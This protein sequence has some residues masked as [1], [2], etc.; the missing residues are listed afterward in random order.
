MA[1]EVEEKKPDRP[2]AKAANSIYPVLNKY[3]EKT[4]SVKELTTTKL[5]MHKENTVSKEGNTH[6]TV[7]HT[8]KSESEKMTHTET[9]LEATPDGHI[10]KPPVPLK[11]SPTP[12]SGVG[13]LFSG[14]RNKMLSSSDKSEKT[15]TSLSSGSSS[16]MEGDKTDGLSS[17]KPLANASTPP[18]SVAPPATSTSP[19]ATSAPTPPADSVTHSTSTFD[20]IERNSIL[21]DP[22]A[23]RVKAPRRRPPSQVLRDESPVPGALSNGHEA[24]PEKVLS[25]KTPEI[26][27]KAREWE[28]HK[29]PWMAELKLNQA[30]KGSDKKHTSTDRLAECGV[31]EKRS[32]HS[33][34]MS[35]STSS[36]SSRISVL[37]SFDSSFE[38]SR[39]SLDKKDTPPDLPASKPPLLS[40]PTAAGRTITTMLDELKKPSLSPPQASVRGEMDKSFE[41]KT[42]KVESISRFTSVREMEAEDREPDKSRESLEKKS[43]VYKVEKSED[44]LIAQ[45]NNRISN[46]EM[47]L[48]A[49]NSRFTA[50]IEEL[51]MRLRAE[52]ESRTALQRELE[53]LSHF[54]TQV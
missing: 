22:R 45:L 54:V 25:D 2:P 36:I 5:S 6:S 18:T 51:N 40:S 4:A 44:P 37:E 7:T 19:P 38:R 30:K 32:S 1:A 28:K 39:N 17:S 35:K 42:E 26:K 9:V 52:T 3:I 50:A 14:L 21:N 46:L 20:H 10:K 48:E 8:N 24:S 27:P 47:L 16:S 43:L 41:I 29:A 11:K 31:E 53:K 15:S 34:E 12:S 49:Q 33:M 13:A 23:G